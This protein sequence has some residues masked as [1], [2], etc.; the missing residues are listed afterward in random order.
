MIVSEIQTGREIPRPWAGKYPFRRMKV[1]ESFEATLENNDTRAELKKVVK[2]AH[3]AGKRNNM[4]F[5]TRILPVNKIGVWRI[6]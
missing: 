4:K 6:S 3:N 1:G 2:A 5:T